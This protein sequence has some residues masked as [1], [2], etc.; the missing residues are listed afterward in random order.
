MPAGRSWGVRR[1]YSLLV[2]VTITALVVGGCAPSVEPYVQ[3]LDALS[4]P[5]GWELARSSSAGAGG[6]VDCSVVANLNCPSATRYYLVREDAPDAYAQIKDALTKAG[7]AV[8]QERTPECQSAE[9]G[10]LCG[11]RAKRDDVAIDLNISPAGR[12]VD[13]LGLADPERPMVRV[14]ARKG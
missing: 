3:A 9:T 10:A 14:I 8:D 4:W 2:C 12:D 6:D 11:L 7:F 13:N 1:L 5:A